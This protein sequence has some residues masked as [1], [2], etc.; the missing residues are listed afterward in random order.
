MDDGAAL[1]Y[2]FQQLRTAFI[3]GLVF[4]EI[5]PGLYIDKAFQE[6]ILRLVAD[7]HHD[8]LVGQYFFD[9]FG[10]A[11]TGGGSDEPLYLLELCFRQAD[12]DESFLFFFFHGKVCTGECTCAPTKVGGM[13]VLKSIK[14]E[15]F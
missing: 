2:F 10:L 12:G 7:L 9:V 11:L 4:D 6:V 14:I 8:G 5:K 3:S 13:E 15:F 1:F